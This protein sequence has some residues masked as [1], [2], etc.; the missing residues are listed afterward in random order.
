[1][2]ERKRRFPRKIVKRARRIPVPGEPIEA[3]Q[4]ERLYKCWYCGDINTTGRDEEDSGNSS[5]SSTYSL[6]RVRSIGARDRD[7]NAI[8]SIN[9]GVF[10]TKSA[11]LK[12]SDGT[13]KPVKNVWTLVSHRYCKACGTATWSG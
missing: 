3:Y 2:I 10:V 4:H 7:P 5:M 8:L 6:P 12:G 11:P 1:M 13:A 9:S